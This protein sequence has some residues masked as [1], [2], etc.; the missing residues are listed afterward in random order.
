MAKAEDLYIMRNSLI[1]GIYK[2]GRS[3]NVQ[4]RALTL[5]A[6]QPLR[7][8]IV[9]VFPGAAF[10]EKAI[11]AALK[12]YR[13]KGPGVEWFRCPLD[14]ILHHIG[15]R[16]PAY[17]TKFIAEGGGHGI[18]GGEAHPVAD[19]REPSDAA[20]P[21]LRG[22]WV[23]SVDQPRTGTSLATDGSGSPRE[24]MPDDG[25]LSVFGE[26]S[27][28]VLAVGEEVAVQTGHHFTPRQHTGSD[29]FEGPES[30]FD[31]VE[32]VARFFDEGIGPL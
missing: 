24:I 14:T 15:Q 28:G 19:P 6:S 26:L 21:P 1:P 7:I 5:Q 4:K 16:L 8:V 25:E 29:V 27:L 22:D 12:H 3:S 31:G 23:P 10:L 20:G 2:V 17:F 18:E 13:V 11:H 32:Y 30:G 9:A